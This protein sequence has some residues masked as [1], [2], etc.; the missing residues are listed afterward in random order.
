MEILSGWYSGRSH[1]RAAVTGAVMLLSFVT[2][3]AQPSSASGVSQAIP[4]IWQPYELT[5][6][7]FGFTTYYSCS[8][9]ED[10]LEQ[11]L[12]EMGADKD[13]RVIATGCF[14]SADLGKNLTAHI[15]VRM[16]MAP[17][18]PQEQSFL[19]TSRP[20]TLKSGGFGA[21]GSGDCELLEQVR[22]Q[23][24][25]ALKLQLIKDSLG[26]IPGHASYSGHSL[27]VMALVPEAITK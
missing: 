13:V 18:E 2:L 20:V 4:A 23:I 7:Y 15:R 5:F 1:L 17:S 8:A 14:G 10:R 11:M 9:L 24:L 19:A 21:V 26:C 27:Q 6:H 16:P 12:Q 25:P 3:H 22:D